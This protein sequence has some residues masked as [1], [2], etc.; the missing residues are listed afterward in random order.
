VKLLIKA[1]N[2][3]IEVTAALQSVKAFGSDSKA[4]PNNFNPSRTFD[5]SLVSKSYIA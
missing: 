3:S 1:T 4:Y 5:S 2:F